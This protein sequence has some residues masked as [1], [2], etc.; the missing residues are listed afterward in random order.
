ML[1]SCPHIGHKAFMSV[2]SVAGQRNSTEF[3]K[4]SHIHTEM[5]GQ[6]QNHTEMCGVVVVCNSQR[7]LTVTAIDRLT[8][9]TAVTAMSG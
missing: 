6:S 4:L 7:L 9:V 3:Y 8:A 1:C 5:C 2:R